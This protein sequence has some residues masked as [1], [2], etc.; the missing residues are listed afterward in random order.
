MAA[1]S[2]PA[3]GEEQTLPRRGKAGGAPAWDLPA[4][5]VIAAIFVLLLTG[6]APALGPQLAGL[7]AP[8]PLYASI[9]VIFAHQQ[10]GPHDAARVLRGL[11]L[12][13]FAFAGFFL[14]LSLLLGRMS[15]A[16]AFISAIVVALLVEGVTLFLIRRGK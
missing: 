10:Q 16:G 15:I 1:E 7:L 4:R 11:L 6:L 2:E 13:Q 8:F 12:G 3:Y 14:S 9:L 5:M